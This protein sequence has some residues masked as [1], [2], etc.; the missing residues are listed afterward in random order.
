[1]S[2]TNFH[3]TTW[4]CQNSGI[5][6][7]VTKIYPD[8]SMAFAV[9]NETGSCCLDNHTSLAMWAEPMPSNRS[10]EWLSKHRFYGFEDALK[11]ADKFVSNNLQY[12]YGGES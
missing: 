2:Y 10:D 1:M 12:V 6:I 9:R 7:Q 5:K 8:N 11:A 3:A 4:T